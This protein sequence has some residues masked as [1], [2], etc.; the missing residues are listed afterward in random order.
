M[1]G[2]WCC[3][4]W[5]HYRTAGDW[6]HLEKTIV[7]PPLRITIPL[8]EL[9]E[10]ESENGEVYEPSGDGDDEKSVQDVKLGFEKFANN[11]NVINNET[12]VH[13][14]NE[15]NV[16]VHLVRKLPSG[17]IRT[18][19]V[20]NNV[21][22]VYD[23]EVAQDGEDTTSPDE[24]PTTE[25]VPEKPRCCKIVSPRVCQ[26]QADEWVCFHRKQYVCSKVCTADEMYLRPRRITYRNPWLIMP[27]GTNRTTEPCF[28]GRCRKP[29]CSGCLRGKRGCHSMCYTYDC[30]VDN[31]CHF[32]DW[33]MICPNDLTKVC[34]LLEEKIVRNPKSS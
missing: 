34:T 10:P 31:T 20:R 4:S 5:S 23:E 9:P 13:T 32:L 25:M 27:P 17:A 14:V 18:E 8:P 2:N 15:N 16:V 19:I 6:S 22:T 28:L 33:D 11:R 24:L 26:K 12:S 3:R 1:T 29:D 30:A 7:V 21:T